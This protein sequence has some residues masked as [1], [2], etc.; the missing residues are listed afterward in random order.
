MAA[1]GLI[2]ALFQSGLDCGERRALVRVCLETALVSMDELTGQL[3][4][5]IVELVGHVLH[6][7]TQAKD[8]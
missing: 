3:C 8:V 4:F 2:R 5:Q 6:D 1:G 7:L